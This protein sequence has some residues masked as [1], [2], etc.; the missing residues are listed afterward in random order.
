MN[1][2]DA[3]GRLARWRLRLAE[4]D[5]QVEYRPGANHHAADAMSR[6]PH[7]PVPDDAIEVEIPVLTVEADTL[8]AET[9]SPIAELTT[10]TVD[11]LFDKQCL[12]PSVQHLAAK[13]ISDP[14]WDY[15]PRGILGT[16]HP[17]GE[18]EIHI[19]PSVAQNSPCVVIAATEDGADLGWGY[20][21]VQSRFRLLQSPVPGPQPLSRSTSFAAHRRMMRIAN[22][23]PRPQ[24]RVCSSTLTT[25]ESWF[26]LLRLTMSTK[27]WYRSHSWHESSMR[28]IT[29][30]L[31]RTQGHTGCFPPSDGRFSGRAWQRMSATQSAS[32]TPARGTTMRRRIIRI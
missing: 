4:F 8:E 30:Q 29:R 7:Q 25:E 24:A 2:S 14:R 3:Q 9:T 6:I 22:A 32:V 5:F 23:G 20:R 26:G 19:P 17:S 31:R 12:D 27:W 21:R 1:L 13:L 28:S 18:F 10:L 15:D 11:A 16:I